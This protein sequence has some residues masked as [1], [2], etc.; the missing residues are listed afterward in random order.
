MYLNMAL[1]IHLPFDDQIL[2]SFAGI[3]SSVTKTPIIQSIYK[4][5]EEIKEEVIYELDHPEAEKMWT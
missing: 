3:V 5:F 1:S 4:L 2:S